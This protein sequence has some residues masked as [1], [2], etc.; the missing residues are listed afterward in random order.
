MRFAGWVV[1]QCA[2]TLLGDHVAVLVAVGLQRR[3][4]PAGTEAGRAFCRD[5]FNHLVKRDAI[6]RIDFPK[7]LEL[8][9]RGDDG[10]VPVGSQALPWTFAPATSGPSAAGLTVAR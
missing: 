2:P 9:V 7:K 3:N 4:E 10:G 5:V 6:A 8:R 1:A